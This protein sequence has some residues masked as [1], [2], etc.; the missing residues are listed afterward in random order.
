MSFSHHIVRHT[1]GRLIYKVVD[2]LN[3]ILLGKIFDDW[4]LGQ[5]NQYIMQCSFLIL[6]LNFGLSSSLQYFVGKGQLDPKRTS[7]MSLVVMLAGVALLLVL[8]EPIS[9]WSGFNFTTKFFTVGII[10]YALFGVW[11]ELN[12][13]LCISIKKINTINYSILIGPVVILILYLLYWADVIHLGFRSLV[14]LAIANQLLI[15]ILSTTTVLSASLTPVPKK[16][17]PLRDIFSFGMLIYVTNLVQFLVYRFDYWMVEKHDLVHFP[18][19][20]LAAQMV[21][22]LWFVPQRVADI[23]YIYTSEDNKNIHQIILTSAGL[24]LYVQI[25]LGILF[26]L[27]FLAIFYILDMTH[28]FQSIYYFLILLVPACLFGMGII[29]SSY[30]AGRRR[31]LIN[32][33]TSLVSAML[34]IG[35]S[36]WIIP[37]FGVRGALVESGIVYTFVF[38]FQYYYFQKSTPF[39]YKMLISEPIYEIRRILNE[40]NFSLSKFLSDRQ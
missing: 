22:F 24:M 34:A 33:V 23:S 37:R 25:I 12:Y 16:Q 11:Q 38:V 19:F 31:L 29:F 2:I 28:F 5:Y 36:L 8:R 21:S 39:S 3:I 18:Y 13:A 20:T 4:T 32:F 6:F 9:R 10:A 35:L 1:S 27:A 40:K 26:C 17:I 14:T 30:Q 7:R 15:G